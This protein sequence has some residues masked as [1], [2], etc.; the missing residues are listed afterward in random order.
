L[1]ETRVLAGSFRPVWPELKVTPEELGTTEVGG[2]DA[3]DHI[4]DYVAKRLGGIPDKRQRRKM[5]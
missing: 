3:A 2:I 5:Q 1:L 4:G